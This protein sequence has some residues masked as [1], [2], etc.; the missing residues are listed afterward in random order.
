LLKLGLRLALLAILGLLLV[1]GWVRWATADYRFADV[2]SIPSQ[3][4]AI[5]FGAGIRYNQPS[6]ALRER[7]ARWRNSALSSRPRPAFAHERR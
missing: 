4:V 5:V 1:N 2:A 3:P 6:A 7:V